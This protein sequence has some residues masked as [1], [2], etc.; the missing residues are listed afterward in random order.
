LALHPP[1]GG[2]GAMRWQ[3]IAGILLAA[4]GGFLVTKYKP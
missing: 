2:F 3:F 1:A 4:L